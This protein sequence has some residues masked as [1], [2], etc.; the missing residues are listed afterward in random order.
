MHTS[1]ER[2]L[3]ILLRLVILCAGL[4]F[5]IPA[6]AKAGEHNVHG[7]VLDEA[8][9]PVR[10]VQVQL[11]SKDGSISESTE[12]DRKGEFEIVHAPNATQCFLEVIA[13]SKLGLASAIVEGIPGNETRNVIVTLKKG[14]L[15]SGRVVGNDKGLKGIIV[16]AISADLN[17]N[18]KARIHG[19]G[20]VVT[21]RGG[22]FEMVLTPGRKKLVLLNKQ[23]SEFSDHAEIDV[24]VSADT[25]IGNIEVPPEG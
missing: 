8:N 22:K 17:K 9:E 12:T 21:D 1:K 4:S 11:W 24:T 25:D 15:V 6:I 14:F 2:S 7:T 13:P 5:L 16:K 20:A 3:R 23:Y 10:W 18:E 19:G